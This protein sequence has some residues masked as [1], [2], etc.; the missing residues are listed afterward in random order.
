MLTGGR[1]WG[2][3]WAMTELLNDSQAIQ[4]LDRTRSMEEP[5][6][7]LAPRLTVTATIASHA[8]AASPLV[9]AR[10]MAS[11]AGRGR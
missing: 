10:S 7:H 5:A 11:E 6:A 3:L 4:V 9:A 1:V 8:T 2:G